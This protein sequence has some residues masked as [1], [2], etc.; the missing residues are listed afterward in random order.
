MSDLTANFNPEL[1]EPSVRPVERDRWMI[2]PPVIE[3]KDRRENGGHWELLVEPVGEMVS[4]VRFQAIETF[5]AEQPTVQLAPVETEWVKRGSVVRIAAGDT[6]GPCTA[7]FIQVTMLVHAPTGL[8]PVD[9]A[10]NML[11]VDDLP[12]GSGE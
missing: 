5:G 6:L 12:G 3:V 2:T 4:S 11:A 9:F 7:A 8:P 1:S 10:L